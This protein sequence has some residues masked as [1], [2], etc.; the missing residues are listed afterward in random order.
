LV[1]QQGRIERV[2]Q[3]ELGA[4]VLSER[5]GPTHDV[6]ANRGVIHR[7]ED[8][9]GRL[10]YAAINNECRDGK[11]ANQALE[12][13]APSPVQSLASEHDK[14]SAKGCGRLGQALDR[15]ADFHLYR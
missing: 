3:H 9:P 6:A 7:G 13:T 5:C 14:L 15:R 8:A 11:S 10:A 4:E 2:Q 1:R 12:G